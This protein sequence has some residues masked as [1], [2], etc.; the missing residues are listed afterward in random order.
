MLPVACVVTGLEKRQR[1]GTQLGMQA[2]SRIS[3]ND[4]P[5]G[6]EVKI[7]RPQC[8]TDDHE[9]FSVE[10]EVTVYNR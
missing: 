5:H 4:I 10:Q 2:Y 3:T 1:L 7:W 6:T 8:I 9:D